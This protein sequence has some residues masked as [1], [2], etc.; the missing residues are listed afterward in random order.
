MQ[1]VRAFS[2][3]NAATAASVL[4]MNQMAKGSASPG[5][6]KIGEKLSLAVDGKSLK[7]KQ[8]EPQAKKQVSLFYPHQ[9]M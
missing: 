2:P 4:P 9:L 5:V 6:M 1:E 3:E 7:K 8:K